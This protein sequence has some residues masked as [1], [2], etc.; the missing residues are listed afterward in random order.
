MSR[1]VEVKVIRAP[2]LEGAAAPAST[3][4][5]EPRGTLK[6]Y[7][8]RVAKFVPA[9]VLA[10]YTGA[11]QLILTH[12]SATFR[13]VAFAIVGLIALIA[14]PIWLGRFAEHPASK[15]PNQVM[16]SIAFIAWAYAYPAGFF[17][18]VGWHE[19]VVAGLLLLGFTF[20]S[21]F[22]QPTVEQS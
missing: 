4:S 2:S 13:L 9:E 21:G 16:G 8:E 5:Q 22:Y 11:V 14:T 15:R 20:F 6:E 17:Y 18:G 10:F 12:Q 3:E 1:L 7:G 19:P